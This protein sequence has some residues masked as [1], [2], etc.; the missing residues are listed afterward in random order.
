MKRFTRL[1]ILTLVATLPFLLA[2]DIER[3]GSQRVT[4]NP[5]NFN[6]DKQGMVYPTNNH[7]SWEGEPMD[8]R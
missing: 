8:Y 4:V 6:N 2:C 5:F 7:R 1:L 3:S